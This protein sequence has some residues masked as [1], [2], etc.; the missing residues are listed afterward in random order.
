MGNIKYMVKIPFCV[1]EGLQYD[2]ANSS[3]L[4]KEAIT[5]E[6]STLMVLQTFQSLKETWKQLKNGGYHFTPH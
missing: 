3:D 2:N 5:K 4:W 1:K 6:I